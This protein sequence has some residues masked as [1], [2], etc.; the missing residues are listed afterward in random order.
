MMSNMTFKSLFF[1][2]VITAGF[3]A[4][5]YGQPPLPP[6]KIRSLQGKV[7]LQ[8]QGSDWFPAHEGTELD[9]GMAFRIGEGGTLEAASGRSIHWFWFG[10]GEGAVGLRSK[11]QNA[12]GAAD[13]ELRKGMIAIAFHSAEADASFLISTPQGTV[14]F[15]TGL[16]GID[17]QE[18]KQLRI[19]A[20]E[21]SACLKRAQSKSLCADDGKMLVIDA[22]DEKPPRI[23]PVDQDIKNVWKNMD[24]LIVG[25]KP[26]IKVLQPQEGA[27][28]TESNI[29]VVGSTSKGATVTINNKEIEVKRDGSFSGSVSLYEG[30]NRL[31]VQA[32]SSSGKTATVTRAVY[33]DTTPPLL[34]ISQPTDNFD[35]SQIG[36]CDEDGS[37]CYIQIFGITEPGVRLIANGLNVSRFIEDD[38]SF[39]IQDF[40]IKQN[41]HT[42]RIEA[43]DMNQRRTIEILNIMQP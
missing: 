2:F 18:N 30:E 5:S 28:F 39:F 34:T 3:A 13:L 29:F 27:S 36:T 43:S 17:W 14:Q 10:P 4:W 15:G 33:L 32:R 25:N 1:V 31:V 12:A 24:W 42:L 38:G 6:L 9:P 23:V 22:K 7:D 21:G 35:P 41:E 16:F 40:P 19:A 11:N 20:S 37:Y 8:I 26:E